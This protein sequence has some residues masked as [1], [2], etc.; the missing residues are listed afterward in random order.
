MTNN[1]NAQ[2]NWP[3]AATMISAMIG[4]AAASW[5]LATAPA[6]KGVVADGDRY[7]SAR[8]IGEVKARL[9]AIEL[10][11]QQ[12]RRELRSDIRELRDL[13]AEVVK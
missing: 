11:N 7:A 5:A 6:E 4:A 13:L 10:S 3:A 1:M 9:T 2:L 8:E 12:L